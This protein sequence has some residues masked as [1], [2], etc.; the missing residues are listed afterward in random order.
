MHPVLVYLFWLWIERVQCQQTSFSL[1]NTGSQRTKSL[2]CPLAIQARIN[3]VMKYIK[4]HS[5]LDRDLGTRFYMYACVIIPAT[6][7]LSA[8]G[9]VSAI[10]RFETIHQP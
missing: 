10:I 1:C 5:N 8:F 2:E 4:T 3:I 7:N 9:K 6:P